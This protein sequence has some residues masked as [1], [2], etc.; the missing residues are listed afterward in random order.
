MN[1]IQ[2]IINLTIKLLNKVKLTIL[3]NLI[4]LTI[5]LLNKVKLMFS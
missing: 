1:L 5:K 2:I 4:N 3:I